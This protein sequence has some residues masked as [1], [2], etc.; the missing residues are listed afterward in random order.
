MS[1]FLSLISPHPT[2]LLS[3]NVTSILLTQPAF[4][5]LTFGHIQQDGVVGDSLRQAV[6]HVT[7]LIPLL[8]ACLLDI[9]PVHHGLENIGTGGRIQPCVL[10]YFRQA[11][12]FGGILRQELQN[13]ECAMD[14]LYHDLPDFACKG[15]YFFSVLYRF[16]PQSF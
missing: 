13:I 1:S 14:D 6:R 12:L 5:V 9:V 3:T 10:Y 2:H 16:I 4:Q 7:Q 8:G 11:E 15:I